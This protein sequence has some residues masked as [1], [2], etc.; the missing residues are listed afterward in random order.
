MG[1]LEYAIMKVKTEQMS[2]VNEK[3]VKIII[4]G[5]F[6]IPKK[7]RAKLFAKIAKDSRFTLSN[8]G[9]IVVRKG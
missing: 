3:E 2:N 4:E 8:L 1:A 7:E 9:N 5:M 6:Y